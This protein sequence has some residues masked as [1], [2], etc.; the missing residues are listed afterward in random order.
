MSDKAC[1]Q[2]SHVS[3]SAIYRTKRELNLKLNLRS[4]AGAIYST[5]FEAAQNDKLNLML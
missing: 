1:A 2:S 4:V 5:H 3:R